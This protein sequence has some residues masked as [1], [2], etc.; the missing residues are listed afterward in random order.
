MDK[1]CTNCHRVGLSSLMKIAFDSPEKLTYNAREN[2]V[3][4]G[5]DMH[6]SMHGKQIESVNN[7]QR[8]CDTV[9]DHQWVTKIFAH[10]TLEKDTARIKRTII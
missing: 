3:A 8:Y 2:I 10:L 7:V 4:E 1:H 6:R 5:L 9:W